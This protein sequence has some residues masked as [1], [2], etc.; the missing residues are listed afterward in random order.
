MAAAIDSAPWNY[1]GVDSFA[2]HSSFEALTEGSNEA[3]ECE[4][5]QERVAHSADGSNTLEPVAEESSP[6]E[7]RG[8]R[9]RQSSEVSGRNRFHGP[10]GSILAAREL[11]RLEGFHGQYS[12]RLWAINCE[13]P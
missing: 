12:M 10:G 8:S 3:G 1:P 4:N 6:T 2:P 13:L 11:C 7:G 9:K 5:M